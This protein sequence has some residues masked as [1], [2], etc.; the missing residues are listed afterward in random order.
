MKNLLSYLTT[1]TTIPV[2]TTLA[3]EGSA[4]DA[5]ATGDALSIINN[6]FS[7]LDKTN[8]NV[9]NWTPVVSSGADSVTE[10]EGLYIKVGNMCVLQFWVTGVASTTEAQL[11]ITG[12]PFPVSDKVSEVCGGGLLTGYKALS[13]DGKEKIT[14]SS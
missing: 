1:D 2:D 12:I 6:T 7:K 5:K 11:K 10:A 14:F 4:A 9:G 3:L 13:D 8:A